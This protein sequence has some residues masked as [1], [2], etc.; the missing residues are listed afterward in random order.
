MPKKKPVNF[1]EL[2]EVRPDASNMDIINAYRQAKLTYKPESLAAYSLFDE[3]E[4]ETIRADIEQAYLALSSPEKRRTYDAMLAEQAGTPAKQD[5]P[6]PTVSPS[7]VVEMSGEAH[8]R[9]PLSYGR[10]YCFPRSVTERDQGI[11]RH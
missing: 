7:N 9:H 2:L 11:Q 8:R 4:L 5:V 10:R 6:K 1:Y 3:D